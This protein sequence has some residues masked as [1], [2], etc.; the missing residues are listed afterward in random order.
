MKP[1]LR[2]EPHV[3]E[4]CNCLRFHCRTGVSGAK[5]L[6]LSDPCQLQVRGASFRLTLLKMMI[7]SSTASKKTDNNTFTLWEICAL[8]R[9]NIPHRFGCAHTT[10][11]PKSPLTETKKSHS[12]HTPST[13]LPLLHSFLCP[14]VHF[15]YFNYQ[16]RFYPWWSCNAIT[17]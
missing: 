13:L 8:K 7:F 16:G 4:D 2:T 14:H 12:S 1:V 10:A 6:L 3:S 9:A 5:G 15:P 11:P 17:L